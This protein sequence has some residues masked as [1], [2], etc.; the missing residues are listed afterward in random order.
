[1]IRPPTDSPSVLAWQPRASR[2]A[3]G[4][5]HPHARA[6]SVI[7]VWWL[8]LLLSG[9]L[10]I[11]SGLS[12]MDATRSQTVLT[13]PYASPGAVLTDPPAAVFAVWWSVRLRDIRILPAH[14][15]QAPWARVALVVR[16]STPLILA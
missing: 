4:F 5:P 2:G 15:G 11:I 14:R 1:M 9:S 7:A 10:R 16:L 12:V 8:A 3:R 13:T 6:R